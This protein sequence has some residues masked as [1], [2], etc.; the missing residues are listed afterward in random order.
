MDHSHAKVR[1]DVA[2]ERL[3]AMG[4]TGDE[5]TV[6]RAVA[7]AK[8]AY[9]AGHRRTY[10]PWIPEPGMWLQ[11][12]DHHRARTEQET[13]P[14]DPC[15][16][17]P[18]A[19]NHELPGT[20]VGHR[21]PSSSALVSSHGCRRSATW[22]ILKFRG[23]RTAST[24]LS[25]IR[26]STSTSTR[27]PP[28]TLPN[29]PISRPLPWPWKWATVLPLLNGG[30]ADIAIGCGGERRMLALENPG[31]GVHQLHTAYARTPAGRAKDRTEIAFARFR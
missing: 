13:E 31:L 1:A 6:R 18:P 17:M 21:A 25:V 16:P 24:A 27:S 4:F 11:R 9:R 20:S 8:A 3:L 5:R 2:Y 22:S 7:E 14:P 15:A 26:C 29:Q 10:R 19:G 28:M 30:R 23:F 12:G